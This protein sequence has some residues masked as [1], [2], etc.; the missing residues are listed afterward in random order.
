MP[1]TALPQDTARAIG[2]TSVISDPCS[3]VKELLDNALDASATSV[4]IEISQNTVDVIQV[5]DNGRGIPPSDHALVCRRAHTSKIATVEDLKKIGGS[6]LGFRGEALAS[7]AEVSGGVT[8]TTRVETEPVASVIKYGR[9]GGVTSVQRASHPVGTTVRVSDLF[10]HIPV[11]RQTT[12]R[13][14]TKNL[15]RVK[16]LIQE[17]AAAQPSKRL[18]L[19]VLKAKNENGNWM[20]APKPN[21][22]LMDAALK[23]AG[24]DVASTCVLKH[25]PFTEAT[26]EPPY[27]GSEL[28]CR[29]TAL[30]LDPNAASRGIG[31][32]I[33]KVYKSYVRSAIAAKDSST[34]VTD[35]FLCLHVHCDEAMYD[36]NIEPAK[37]DVLFEDTSSILEAIEELC[38]NV[39]GDK[40]GGTEKGSTSVKGKQPIRQRDGFELLLASSQST[41][42]GQQRSPDAGE[43]G[44]R[45]PSPVAR[46]T[47]QPSSRRME[48]LSD[49]QR[50]YS[51]IRTYSSDR[52]SL[53]PWNITKIITPFNR[54]GPAATDTSARR[55]SMERPGPASG[56]HLSPEA[57]SRRS[58][59]ASCLP[60][61]SASNSC[62][63]SNSPPGVSS[64]RTTFPISQTSP[65]LRTNYAK[66]AARERD[67][68][69]Y[70]NG[71][72]DTWFG[73]TTQVALSRITTED[74]SSPEEEEQP[75]TRLAQERFGSATQ[76]SPTQ[77]TP[78]GCT[79]F[80]SQM[81]LP[82][83]QKRLIL[84]TASAKLSRC[85]G[86]RSGNVMNNPH[87]LA[88]L[89]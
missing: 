59:V 32:N 72:L 13:N 86:N 8:V 27:M 61:P 30:V 84:R 31:K 18:S 70:G 23:I 83:W 64:P 26:S 39:Y 40:E 35:P 51:D 9:D 41:S 20:Y 44:N 43:A 2:S 76:P 77:S 29:M 54:T 12:L 79:S 25:W 71:S 62:P 55:L 88:L 46:S 53:N 57:A 5:K 87:L 47:P 50:R 81:P 56:H 17:Y 37:D 19:K 60:S 52:E 22:S 1:I 74:P 34:T 28:D 24:T 66:R 16:R 38:R 11:R 48:G 15:A 4:F 89:I 21:A 36:V 82:A 63:T 80:P 58:S 75:L 67:R 3:V 65:S 45:R 78:A 42:Q 49:D 7:T 85:D 33:A 6:S 73:K 14:T 69:R 10:K 68:E